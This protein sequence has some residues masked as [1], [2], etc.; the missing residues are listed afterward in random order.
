[1]PCR[2]GALPVRRARQLRPPLRLG[3]EGHAASPDVRELQDEAVPG[4]LR[5][6]VR[7]AVLPAQ[8]LPQDR[9]PDPRVDELRAV[10]LRLQPEHHGGEGR[11]PVRAPV[12]A[13]P[14]ALSAS[15]RTAEIRKGPG[16]AEGG[17]RVLHVDRRGVRLC[18][19]PRQ[20]AAVSRI[21]A[22]VAP[23]AVGLHQLRR[24]GRAGVHLH[25]GRNQG[26]QRLQAHAVHEAEMGASR[27]PAGRGP[28]QR[29]RPTPST[30][31]GRTSS[32]ATASWACGASRKCG[33]W[34]T[35]SATC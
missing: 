34:T 33:P 18:H 28:L 31:S 5:G 35:T 4:R 24:A 1:M 3:E 6:V 30:R 21:P 23:V 11:V 22:M 12:L 14:P 16:P 15:G 27:V 17:R 2:S 25:G 8:D 7:E 10:P 20:A 13:V 9:L 26:V 19:R 32:S 29:L